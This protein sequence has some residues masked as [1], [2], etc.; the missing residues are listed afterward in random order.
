M[1]GYNGLRWVVFR[2]SFPVSQNDTGQIGPFF[3][4]PVGR[5]RAPLAA[6]QWEDEGV[7]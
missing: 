2:C 4:S 5:R 1:S 3:P 6:G 7:R